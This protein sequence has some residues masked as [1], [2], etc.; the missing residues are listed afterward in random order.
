LEKV[1]ADADRIQRL[2]D[3]R[4]MLAEQRTKMRD[5]HSMLTNAVKQKFERLK[6]RG[7]LS[8]LVQTGELD[9]GAFLASATASAEM[10]RSAPQTRGGLKPAPPSTVRT[11]TGQGARGSRGQ[12]K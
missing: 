11:S 8:R 5:E 6:K 2:K 10:A 9:V 7:E 1:S 3:Q 12:P 4:N